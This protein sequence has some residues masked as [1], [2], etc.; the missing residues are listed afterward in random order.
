MKRN[1]LLIALLMTTVAFIS[2][3]C[4][5]SQ[6]SNMNMGAAATPQPT[7]DKAAIEAELTKIENDPVPCRFFRI[8]DLCE[9]QLMW[10]PTAGL[11]A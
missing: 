10:H 11:P 8:A 9:F 5:T 4:S 2:A 7:P 6:N 3:G 1:H